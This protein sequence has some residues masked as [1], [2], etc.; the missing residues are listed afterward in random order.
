MVTPSVRMTGPK[1]FAIQIDIVS[2]RFFLVDFV[3][4]HRVSNTLKDSII[5][6]S[7]D[8][9]VTGDKSADSCAKNV[10]DSKTLE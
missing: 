4:K 10:H 7:T 8:R 6:G 5:C 9:C 3:D 1:S 2:L